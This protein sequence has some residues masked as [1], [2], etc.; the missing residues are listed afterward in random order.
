MIVK[1][2]LVYLLSLPETV[3]HSIAQDLRPLAIRDAAFLGIDAAPGH[4][5]A[6]LLGLVAQFLGQARFTN[7]CLTHQQSTLGAAL[8]VLRRRRDHFFLSGSLR[9]YSLLAGE[10]HLMHDLK[11]VIA[12]NQH[13]LVTAAYLYLKRLP[14]GEAAF[15]GGCRII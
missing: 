12:P 13:V 9:T 6:A 11:F 14:S 8:C 5:P 3:G 4:S 2:V 10:Q 7:A 15:A 1:G